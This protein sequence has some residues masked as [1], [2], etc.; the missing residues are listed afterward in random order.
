[1]S[2][3]SHYSRPD[4]LLLVERLI[5]AT[6][7][8]EDHPRSGRRVPEAGNHNHIRELIL[9]GYRIIY[10]VETEEINI[11]TVIHGSRDLAGQEGKVWQ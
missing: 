3:F 8:L 10:R 6:D 1:M 2:P 4:P 7:R 11:L 5:E 9:Q